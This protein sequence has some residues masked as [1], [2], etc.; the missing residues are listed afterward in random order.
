MTCEGDH[1]ALRV[2]LQNIKRNVFSTT[3]LPASGIHDLWVTHVPIILLQSLRPD[4]VI[5]NE[6]T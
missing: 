4:K 3:A 2:M 5:I 1:V 6:H